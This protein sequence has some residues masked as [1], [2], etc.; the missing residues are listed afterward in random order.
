[1]IDED[2]AP[3]ERSLPM[4]RFFAI[5]LS[6]ILVSTLLPLSAMADGAG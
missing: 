1:M 2:I 6:M 3:T 4:K 5:L